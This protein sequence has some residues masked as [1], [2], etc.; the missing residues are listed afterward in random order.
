MP[1]RVSQFVLR[2]READWENLAPA[3]HFARHATGMSTGLDSVLP[4][5]ATAHGL[6]RKSFFQLTCLLET[7]FM[8]IIVSLI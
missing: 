1:R 6:A 3:H 5:Q 2:Q 7:P 8:Q 4:T